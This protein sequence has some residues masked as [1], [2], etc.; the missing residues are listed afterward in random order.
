MITTIGGQQEHKPGRPGRQRRDAGN[1][2]QRHH[3]L[4]AE[5]AAKQL[6]TRPSTTCAR[7]CHKD[8]LRYLLCTRTSPSS[9]TWTRRSPRPTPRC[10]SPVLEK[11]FIPQVETTSSVDWRIVGVLMATDPQSSHPPDRLQSLEGT[12]TKWNP[13]QRCS[14][15][16]VDTEVPSFQSEEARRSTSAPCWRASAARP[17]L[18]RRP[19]PGRLAE[20]AN[21]PPGTASGD[22]QPP[23]QT[24]DPS[25]PL[26]SADD[27]RSFVSPV[28]RPARD[29]T[30]AG[31]HSSTADGT[32]DVPGLFRV[33][34]AG[35]PG[36]HEAPAGTGTPAPPAA[37]P[38]AHLCSRS[39]GG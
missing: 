29:G 23:S 31:L 21:A 2:L 19:R 20:A 17:G 10:F 22:A 38:R 4:Q 36:G 18:L 32:E 1:H 6:P 12:V 11:A 35:L 26:S 25:S 3:G 5:E 16:K 37:P 24:E 7:S 8:V 27:G 14:T 33:R 9:K 15:D 30:G 34:P 39:Y 13:G 28:V